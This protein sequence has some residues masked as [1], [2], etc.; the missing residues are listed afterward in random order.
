MEL[1][2][3]GLELEL[4]LLDK[5]KNILEPRLY[6]FPADEMGF[7]LV[8]AGAQRKRLGCPRIADHQDQHRSETPGN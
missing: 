5:N 1:L 2:E 4:F 7:R 8:F 6:G 3:V